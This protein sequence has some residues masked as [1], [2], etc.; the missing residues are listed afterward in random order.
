MKW[1]FE[2][3]QSSTQAGKLL[4]AEC[5]E[6][7]QAVANGFNGHPSPLAIPYFFPTLPASKSPTAMAW[8]I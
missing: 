7:T 4:N 8:R 6:K 3:H 2:E 1:N 5:S